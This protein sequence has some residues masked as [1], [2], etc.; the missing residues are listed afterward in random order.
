MDGV[1]L[2]GVVVAV[3]SC[4]GVSLVVKLF[5]NV[6]WWRCHQ[7]RSGNRC[8]YSSLQNVCTTYIGWL[9]T[10]YTPRFFPC[11]ALI[12][13]TRHRHPGEPC[14]GTRG[15][16][17]GESG[18]G[19]KRSGGAQECRRSGKKEA[20]LPPHAQSRRGISP[21]EPKMEGGGASG[22]GICVPVV[23]NTDHNAQPQETTSAV[24]RLC[25]FP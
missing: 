18:A 12:P 7:C 9:E 25:L 16:K 11:L 10:T 22:G 20:R 23:M 13:P 6:Q 3:C 1:L 24:R 8:R 19:S 21:V 14:H 17:S 4:R 15:R 5:C 2:L